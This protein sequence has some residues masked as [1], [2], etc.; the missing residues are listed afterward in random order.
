MLF[1]KSHKG[2][3]QLEPCIFAI[4]GLYEITIARNNLHDI[5]VQGWPYSNNQSC[6]CVRPS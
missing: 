2:T 5:Y 3:K 4:A 6:L 1:P